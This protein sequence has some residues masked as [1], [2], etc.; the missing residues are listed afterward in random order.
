MAKKMLSVDFSNFSNY[1]EKLENLG[2]D[3][4]DIFG[5]VMQE[6]AEEVQNETRAALA[7]GNLPAHGKYS[8]GDTMN[9]VIDDT[10]VTWHGYVGEVS[11]GFDKTKKGSGGFLI[12]GT[13]KMKPDYKLQEI[14][15]TKKY[16]SKIKKEIEET[17]QDE[18]NSRLS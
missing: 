4:Q 5:K 10:S 2:A 18:I 11:L 8:Q 16:E 12:T 6:A 3:L 14:Y 17:L 7:D 15:Q 9:S 1:A 13:P